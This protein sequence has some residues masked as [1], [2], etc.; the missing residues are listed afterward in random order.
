MN[1]ED[2]YKILHGADLNENEWKWNI[3]NRKLIMH[4]YKKC[5]GGDLDKKLNAN[6]NQQKLAMH[7]FLSSHFLGAT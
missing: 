2:G 3:E 4:G 1:F 7:V 6:F 5:I